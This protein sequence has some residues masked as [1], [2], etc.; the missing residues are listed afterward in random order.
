MKN[1]R[2]IRLS[3]FSLSLSLSLFVLCIKICASRPFFSEQK[4]VIIAKVSGFRFSAQK[5]NQ[6]CVAEC[7]PD[8]N[9]ISLAY[10]WQQ[11]KI[12]DNKNI[13]YKWRCVRVFY[14]R[15]AVFLVA[16]GMSLYI[17]VWQSQSFQNLEILGNKI[18]NSNWEIQIPSL[19]SHTVFQSKS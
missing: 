1:S 7:I 2:L 11:Q 15:E 18:G 16:F 9:S 3:P 10:Q 8:S 14:K 4:I 17:M 13:A 5:W 19:L 12:H 6:W